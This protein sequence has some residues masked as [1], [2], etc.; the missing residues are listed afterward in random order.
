MYSCLS[1]CSSKFTINQSVAPLCLL[2]NVG[3][4]TKIIIVKITVKILFFSQ[5]AHSSKIFME[6]NILKIKFRDTRFWKNLLHI[7][8]VF[9]QH[10]VSTTKDVLH[11]CNG[12]WFLKHFFHKLPQSTQLCMYDGIRYHDPY[13]LERK[14]KYN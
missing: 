2:K 11:L 3:S 14:R 5:F 12:V 4:K 10:M 7:C 13:I 1:K 8:Y 6:P 9:C